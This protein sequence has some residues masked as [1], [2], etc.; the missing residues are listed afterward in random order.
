VSKGGYTK[1]LR[2]LEESLAANQQLRDEI[3]ERE[4][5]IPE[6]G[7]I[8]LNSS[9]QNLSQPTP[10]KT[11]SLT[12][13]FLRLAEHGGVLTVLGIAG[14]VMVPLSNW[15]LLLT[16]ACFVLA[17][18]RSE[19]V[20][21]RSRSIQILSYVLLALIGAAAGLGIHVAI[22]KQES[23]LVSR[24]AALT[25]PRGIHLQDEPHIS[26]Q[27]DSP[28]GSLSGKNGEF[29]IH[30]LNQ[31]VDI[32]YVGTK[33]DFFWAENDPKL[34]I[35]RIQTSSFPPEAATRPLRANQSA[36]IPVTF[37]GYIRQIYN[38]LRKGGH[39]GILGVKITIT[40]RRFSDETDFSRS[41]SYEASGNDLQSLS[42]PTDLKP[43]PNGPFLFENVVP[44]LDS[45]DHWS[46]PVFTLHRDRSVSIAKGGPPMPQ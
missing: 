15:F 22:D 35:Y 3:S 17:L 32:D 24:I 29:T 14:P 38:G 12:D 5:R 10:T 41:K 26:I 33:E 20:R 7:A 6:F 28:Q 11:Q 4:N 40:F 30:L 43:T 18:D 39:V 42:P 45:L 36:D 23:E 25:T 44:Y 37:N 13:G 1:I 34:K 8:R 2:K 19:L 16:A 31:G 9:E 21:G 46:D 27:P